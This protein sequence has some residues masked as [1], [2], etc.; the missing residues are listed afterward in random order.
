M[1]HHRISLGPSQRHA[2]QHAAVAVAPAD[3]GG[4]FLMRHQPEIRSRIG[5]SESGER[6]GKFK[7]TGNGFFGC[8]AEFAI[9]YHLV[10][11][12]F[13]QFGVN[14]QAASGFANGNFWGKSHGNPIF[15]G[16]RAQYPF[17]NHQ[18]IGGFLKI[19][20]HKLNFVLLIQFS[21]LRKIAHFGVS[22]FNQAAGL[23]HGGHGFGAQMFP[24]GKR[25]GF[26]ISFLVNSSED[27]LL[28]A[29]DVI[30]QLTHYIEGK[31]GFVLECLMCFAQNVLGR[32]FERFAILV[33]VRAENVERRHIRKRVY[34]GSAVAGHH[35]EV[36]R[37]GLN[38]R[39]EAGAIHP[40]A[41]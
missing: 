21:V 23:S 27:I 19:G 15:V 2:H 4:R 40:F 25:V 14:V 13:H 1:I 39:K 30:F 38:K 31:S 37:S 10:F 7:I 6:R 5:V 34:K 36:A 20:G 29:D 12:V 22:V 41:G 8:V 11:A 18:L 16:Q 9:F 35:V 26:V 33:V 24:F 3:V 32:T 28:V 17:G